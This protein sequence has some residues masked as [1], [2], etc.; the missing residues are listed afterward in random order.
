MTG[1][2]RALA[3]LAGLALACGVGLL[4][5]TA[6]DGVVTGQRGLR[7]GAFVHGNLAAA[8][9]FLAGAV[10]LGGAAVHPARLLV[11]G[12]GTVLLGGAAVHLLGVAAGVDLLGGSGSTVAAFLGLG[13]G[14]LAIGLTGDANP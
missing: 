8:L 10:L 3:V 6:G 14:A 7:L 11:I 2:R 13:A 9:W 1:D 5:L 12:A 4:V